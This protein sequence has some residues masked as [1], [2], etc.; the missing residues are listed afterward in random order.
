[1]EKEIVK[2]FNLPSGKKA[3][4]QKFKG[5]DVLRAQRMADGDSDKVMFAMIATSVLID[6]NPIVME[7]LEEMDGFDV[8]RLMGEFNSGTSALSK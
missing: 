2:E 6:G 4:I 8:V 7:D 3:S 5:L 1:M